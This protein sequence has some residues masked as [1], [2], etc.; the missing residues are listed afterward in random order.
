M[1]RKLMKKKLRG[2]SRGSLPEEQCDLGTFMVPSL[3]GVSDA[4]VRVAIVRV[5][6]EGCVYN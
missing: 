4:G 1:L 2:E 6:S 5:L 3:D